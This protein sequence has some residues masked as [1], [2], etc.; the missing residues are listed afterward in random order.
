[1]SDWLPLISERAFLPWVV[2]IPIDQEV[3]RSRQITNQ[4]IQ[5]IEDMWKADPSA[6][7]DDLQNIA[8]KE[9][10]DAQPVLLR[11]ILSPYFLKWMKLTATIII[12]I[13]GRLSL[14]KCLR[15]TRH[16]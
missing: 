13:R 5:S 4:Q 2:K 16:A 8:V 9:D 11:Y 14:P 10:E 6:I 12:K 1:L 15:T 3:N 7:V